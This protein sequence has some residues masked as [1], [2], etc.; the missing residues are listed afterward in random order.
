VLL[1]EM[2]TLGAMRSGA[3]P[4]G[5]VER[6]S[7]RALR[8]AAHNP[9]H[10]DTG[11]AAAAAELRARNLPVDPWRITAPGFI[12]PADLA[13]GDRLF[14]GWGRRV[15]VWSGWTLN[16]VLLFLLADAFIL[17]IEVNSISA[18]APVVIEMTEA[19]QEAWRRFDEGEGAPRSAILVS[20]DVSRAIGLAMFTPLFVWLL[21]SALRRKPARVLLLCKTTRR[22]L[23]VALRR[24]LR[25]ELR[26]YGHIQ[27]MPDKCSRGVASMLEAPVRCARDYR[28]LARSLSKRVANN[29]RP[30][31]QVRA[32]DAWRGLVARL[33][34][35]SADAIVVDLSD[36]SAAWPIDAIGDAGQRCVFV[37]LWGKAEEAQAELA[38]RGIA[39][40]C[41]CYAP[42][43]EMQRRAQ[44]RV[45]MLDAMRAA[46]RVAP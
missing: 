32:T 44:F 28:A 29:L 41:F 21:A 11:R 33:L 1:K 24:M 22:G 46:H 42:D 14:F 36:V 30:I 27:I 5:V 12:T 19:Q 15:R 35:D 37:S 20:D 25:R 8:A 38:R 16:L 23:D 31:M 45:A 43:G 26:P 40:P 10:S 18:S 17:G 2:R 7:D 6:L 4:S 3:P 34:T 9:D 39:N 13:K